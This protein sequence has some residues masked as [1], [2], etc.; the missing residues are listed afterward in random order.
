MLQVALSKYVGEAEPLGLC[1][2]FVSGYVQHGQLN[3]AE[4]EVLPDLIN[5]RIFSN[6]VYFTGRAIAGVAALGTP[7]CSCKCCTVGAHAS[8]VWLT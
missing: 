5:L 7:L 4:I 6:A 1:E 8:G 2:A 3:D